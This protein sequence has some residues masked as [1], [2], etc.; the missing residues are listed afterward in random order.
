MQFML[1]AAFSK[2]KEKN[3]KLQKSIFLLSILKKQKC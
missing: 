1:H 2:F 3:S